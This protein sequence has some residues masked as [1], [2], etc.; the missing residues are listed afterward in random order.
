MSLRFG[1]FTQHSYNLFYKDNLV[2][3]NGNACFITETTGQDPK[4]ALMADHI[5]TLFSLAETPPL[6]E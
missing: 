5:K 4:V 1:P 2:I 6:K 3:S